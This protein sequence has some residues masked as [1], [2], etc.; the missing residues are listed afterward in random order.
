[1]GYILSLVTTKL[2]P[3]LQGLSSV[4]IQLRKKEKLP[5]T[6]EIITPIL[7]YLGDSTVDVF[8]SPRNSHLFDSPI[9]VVECTF[10]NPPHKSTST[11]RVAYERGHIHW[12]QLKPFVEKFPQILFVLI[13]FSRSL[14]EKE[15]LTTTLESGLS[16]VVL[17]F[18]SGV[19]H[20]KDLL[21]SDV[22]T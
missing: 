5:L 1:V 10:M 11:E 18:D 12:N 17:W 22:T 2:L 3:E 14:S 8:L 20:L 7:S 19:I 21:Q 9:I 6:E 13:H 15:I 4:E 16:N